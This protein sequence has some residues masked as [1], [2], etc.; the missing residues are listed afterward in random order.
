[1]IKQQTSKKESIKVSPLHTKSKEVKNPFL[2]SD[3][4]SLPQIKIYE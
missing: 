1:M 2:I 3:E 4:F